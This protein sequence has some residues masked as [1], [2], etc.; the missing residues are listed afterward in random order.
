MNVLSLFIATLLCE[1]NR[2]LMKHLVRFLGHLYPALLLH[3]LYK[4]FL[5]I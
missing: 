1:V 4:L 2:G 5:Y 3:L